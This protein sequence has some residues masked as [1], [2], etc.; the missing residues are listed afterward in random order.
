VGPE[1]KFTWRSPGFNQTDDHPVVN[2]SWNDAMALS[3]WLSRKE[4]RNY[5]LP[6]EAEWE[7]SCRAESPTRFSFGYDESALG[8]FA[9]YAANSNNQTHP[10]GEK[11][12]NG[13]GL[14][15]LHG[16]VWEWCADGY[17]ADYYKQSPA[18]DPPGS[19]VAAHRVIRGGSWDHDPQFAR[20]ACRYGNTPE[21]RADYLGFRLALAQSGR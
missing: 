7:Y 1:A 19:G 5:R 3:D 11:M 21:Y 17:A 4:A 13:F 12:P 9:W 14:H 15:D 18:A 10:V 16:N 20:S 6:T 2:V 8:E